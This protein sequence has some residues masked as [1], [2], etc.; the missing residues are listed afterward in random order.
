MFANQRYTIVENKT[1]VGDSNKFYY[2]DPEN[3][4]EDSKYLRGLPSTVFRKGYRECIEYNHIDRAEMVVYKKA[5]AYRHVLDSWFEYQKLRHIY[6][7][8]AFEVAREQRRK[9]RPPKHVPVFCKECGLEE[10][11]PRFV[12]WDGEEYYHACD[13]Y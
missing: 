6:A 5:V 8:A 10:W 4:T 9:Q 12:K 3:N 13:C 7:F 2:L 11:S 1:E